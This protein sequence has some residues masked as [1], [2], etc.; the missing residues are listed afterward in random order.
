MSYYTRDP[1]RDHD[2]DNH[3]CVQEVLGLR[4]LGSKLGGLQVFTPGVTL[5]V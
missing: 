5:G 4:V 1:K 2:F 3:P